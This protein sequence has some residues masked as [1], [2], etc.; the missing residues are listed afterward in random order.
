MKDPRSRFS[1]KRHLALLTGYAALS[2][3][4]TWLATTR[5]DSRARWI[6]K[7]LLMPTLAAA[8]TQ[9]PGNELSGATAVGLVGSWVGDVALLGSSNKSF[10]RGMAGF[11]AAQSVYIGAVIPMLD[12]STPLTKNPTAKAIA[13]TSVAATPAVAIAAGRQD[14]TLGTA[15][16]AYGA[17]LTA[18]AAGS[19]HLDPIK[20]PARR[21]RARLLG[22]LLFL[23]SDALIGVRKF[24]LPSHPKALEGAVM[25]TYTAAQLLIVESARGAAEQQG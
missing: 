13:I 16:A 4:D 17:L 14:S 18:H 25:A 6:T 19:A 2:V 3:A 11:A 9:R 7:P 8:M 24:V 21:R 20:I 12:R 10:L 22:A 23:L 15:V 5:E 1:T